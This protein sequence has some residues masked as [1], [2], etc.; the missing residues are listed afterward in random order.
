MAQGS[1]IGVRL[2]QALSHHQAGRRSEAE[3][4]YRAILLDDPTHAGCLHLLGVLYHQG[5]DHAAALDLIGQ[6]IAHDGQVAEFYNNRAHILTLVGR[7]SE[8]QAHLEQ[9]LALRPDYAD[10]HNN[11]G[12]V[13]KSQGKLA[14]AVA[15]Y[16]TVLGRWPRH[17]EACNNLGTVLL[18]QG[19]IED[20]VLR[21]RQALLF[22]PDAPDTL[23]ILGTA[24][25]EQGKLDEAVNRFRRALALNPN[26]LEAR[27][28]LGMTL[29]RQGDTAGA[30]EQF[31]TCRPHDRE[32][33]HG[34]T[35]LLAQLGDAPAPERVS[36]AFITR[37]YAGRG[38][39]GG[40]TY[41]GAI[42]VARLAERVIPAGDRPEVLDAGCGTGG[43]GRRIHTQAARLDGVDL[44]EDMLRAAKESGVYHQLYREDLVSFLGRCK[45]RYDVVTCA[46][47]LIHFGDLA[48]AF[49]ATAQALR[50]GGWFL[51][52]LFPNDDTNGADF[53][54]DTFQGSVLEGCFIHR[55]DYVTA[56]ADRSGFTTL[57]MERVNHEHRPDRVRPTLVLALRRR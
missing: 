37:L 30:R 7:F 41:H 44:S 31:E 2:A 5:G 3:A 49:A 47:T 52:T 50:S 17:A 4:G 36:E 23:A 20:A 12:N 29:A 46:A 55:P 45:D 27:I 24:L 21:L 54:V 25:V 43:V 8:A 57:T 18:E 40:Q 51:F 33:R 19:R 1:P 16:E 34:I 15:C 10:A 56:L 39:P 22:K 42:L 13:Y 48:P 32:D 11:L 6:A 9:A 14:E 38:Q 26:A 53:A 35:L 28:S